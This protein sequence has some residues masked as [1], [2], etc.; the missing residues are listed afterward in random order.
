[1]DS[2]PNTWVRVRLFQDVNTCRVRADN[3]WREWTGEATVVVTADQGQLHVD[4]HTI[5]GLEFL[6]QPRPPYVFHLDDATYRGRLRLR[7]ASEGGTFD[8]INEVPLESYLA[9]VVGA[10]MPAYWEPQALQAQ[11]IAARTYCLYIKHRFGRGRDWDLSRTQAHQVYRGVNAESAQVWD[12][13]RAT[14]GQVL[15]SLGPEQ[16]PYG[17]PAFYSAVCGGHTES[18]N[19]VFGPDGISTHGV[20]CPTCRQVARLSQFF[21]PLVVV[22]KDEANQR[23]KARYPSLKQLGRIQSLVVEGQRDHAE[24]TRITR[25]RLVDENGVSDTLRGEDLRLCLDPSGRRIKS[26]AFT[27]KD[28]GDSWVFQ[29]GRGWGHGVGLCQCGAQGLA[30]AGKSAPEILSF[31]YPETTLVCL[32]SN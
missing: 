14:E 24:F 2:D 30:R 23:L 11:A 4:G 20:T 25:I 12:A 31:Y 17:F 26:T 8:V 7:L 16:D 19:D 6:L 29:Q 18:S 10:E 9:G 3:A 22:T 15:R 27:I 21:W 32:D 28:R 13:L 1:M 5:D